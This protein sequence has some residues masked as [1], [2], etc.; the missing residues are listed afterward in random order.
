MRRS[1]DVLLGDE[2]RPVARIEYESRGARERAAF[3]YTA[4]W[5]ASKDRFT[6]DPT[7]QLVVGMQFHH[8]SR[9]GSIFHGAVADTEPD[10]WAK[11]VILRDHAK[12]RVARPARSLALN[13]LDFLLAVDD[14]ARVGALR[15]RD[16]EGVFRRASEPGRRT[17]PPL[18]DL[19]KLYAATRAVE[20]DTE[21]EADLEY[22]LG[23]ATSL[24]G[25][26]PKCTV[27][28]ADGQL[29]IG[30][31]PSTTDERA[32]T[33]GEVLALRLA[34]CAGIDAAQGRV[35]NVDGVPVAV[36]RRFDRPPG[37][38]R[39]LYVSAATLMGV[40]PREPT[41]HAYTEIVD[42]IRIHGGAVQADI[43][44]LWR[45]IAFPFSSRTSMIICSIMG[46][47]TSRGESGGSRLRST[48]TH[49]PPGRA[50]SRPGSPRRPDPKRPSRGSCR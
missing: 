39:I 44:E 38:G 25:L 41:E 29:A 19:G 47:C 1:I 24:G 2:A 17:V 13:H 35:V 26:R 15:F 43:E 8:R 14:A 22:L 49:S 4:E 31:F 21:S 27:L 46:F 11:R 30:K 37:G 42:A 34:T 9:A 6:I 32:V 5:L 40:D 12:R 10:G 23:R 36:I 28:E 16:E 20:T 45:R 48:S 3:E 7:L 50:S 33:L 18:V